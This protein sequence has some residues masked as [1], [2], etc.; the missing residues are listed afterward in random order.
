MFFAR[1]NVFPRL[2]LR[3]PHAFDL[4]AHI[5]A[6]TALLFAEAVILNDIFLSTL[7]YRRDDAMT[8]Q[9]TAPYMQPASTGM[10]VTA[11]S[12]RS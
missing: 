12:F 5:D 11:L 1:N 2:N 4:L 10:P 3:P 6:F 7:C 9:M 8:V